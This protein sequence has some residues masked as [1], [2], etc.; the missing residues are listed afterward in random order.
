MAQT[1]SYAVDLS[2]FHEELASLI[3]QGVHRPQ[4]LENLRENHGIR[5]RALGERSLSAPPALT[6]FQGSSAPTKRLYRF[7]RPPANSRA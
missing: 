5:S 2:P 4:I 7:Y 6:S 1:R 3:A